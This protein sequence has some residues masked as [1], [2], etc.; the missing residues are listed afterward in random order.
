MTKDRLAALVA[1]SQIKYQQCRLSLQGRKK[2]VLVQESINEKK[3]EEKKT[4]IVS[5]VFPILYYMCDE[6]TRESQ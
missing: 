3:K 5:L 4:L 2:I 1:V 6:V